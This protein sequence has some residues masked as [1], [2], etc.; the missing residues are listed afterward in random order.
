MHIGRVRAIR[1]RATHPASA[2]RYRPS[3]WLSLA[4]ASMTSVDDE[5]G[6]GLPPRL[7]SSKVATS[8]DSSSNDRRVD[9]CS[10]YASANS[11]ASSTS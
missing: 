2:H 1:A 3:V 5:P 7:K 10:P 6:H 4:V 9:D 11:F 8:E